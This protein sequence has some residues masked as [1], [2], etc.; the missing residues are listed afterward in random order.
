MTNQKQVLIIS[1][2]SAEANSLNLFSGHKNRLDLSQQLA[3]K[4]IRSIDKFSFITLNQW[5]V[6]L[7]LNVI[8]LGFISF[9]C[10]WINN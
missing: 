6:L 7:M 2:N 10:S 4:I 8:C 5:I 9:A 1:N 3:N